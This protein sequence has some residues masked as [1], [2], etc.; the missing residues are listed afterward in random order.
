MKP[1]LLILAAWMWSR[2]GWLKQLDTFGV[3]DETILEYSVYDAIR[4]WFGHIIFI[5]RS[6][7]E[8]EF[9]ERIV[10]KLPNTCTYSTVCQEFDSHIPAWFSIDHR[11]K[12]WGTWHAVLVAEEYIKTPFAVVN[13]DDYYWV[14]GYRQIVNFLQNECKS[15]Q[16][17][18]VWYSLEKTLSEHGTVN[19]WVCHVEDWT[20]QK[21]VEHHKI[22]RN[23]WWII[24]D[25]F[26]DEL[27]EKTV[28]SMNFWWFDV[29]FLSIIQEERQNFLEEFGDQPKSEFYLPSV[30]NV[31]IN[32]KSMNCKVMVSTDRWC[33]VTYESDK[34]IVQD[35][36]QKL[37][38][39]WTYPSPLRM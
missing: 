6:S 10:T 19:R 20:L 8:E 22:G 36:L 5:I 1:T 2:Y 24:T 30:C 39:N 29:S 15:N 12:P 21:V 26:D 11:E 9:N 31:A 3:H 34:P 14:D 23:D 25:E 18:M 17:G 16:F 32:S 27:D 38:E 13:A 7:F 28:V 35:Y 33:G 37:H 4:A